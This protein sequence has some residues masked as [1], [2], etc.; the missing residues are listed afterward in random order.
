MTGKTVEFGFCPIPLDWQSGDIRVSTLQ[1]LEESVQ[2]VREDAGV[3]NDWIHSPRQHR[4]D[5]L[6]GTVTELP[7]S[8][9]VFGLP[10]THELEHKNADSD[11]HLSFLVW[12]LG[13]VL[14]IRLTDTEAGFLDATPIVVGKLHDIAWIGDSRRQAFECCERFW[15]THSAKPR[16]TKALAGIVHSLFLAQN[17]SH[18][19]FEKFIYL[20]T[21]LDGCHFVH[22]KTSGQTGRG[23]HAARIANLCD[24][25]DMPVPS[26]ADPSAADVA[27]HRNETI[28]EGLFFDEP[29]GFAPFGSM[30]S[31]PRPRSVAMEMQA[32]VC[33]LLCTL[34]GI[35]ASNYIKSELTSR[36]RL[37]GQ[38]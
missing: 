23:T 3:E 11:E 22:R 29:L 32:L 35:P 28:H 12:C 5:F 34:L 30:R 4:R 1:D 27:D 8:A 33:R 38:L 37:G 10:M 2:S 9:R 16:V 25:F 26:W 20:Y 6:S 24:A 14:G 31:A 36:S 15:Q 21:A 18:L 7:R 19:G 17:P 13:F